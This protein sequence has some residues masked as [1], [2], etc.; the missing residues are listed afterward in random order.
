[1]MKLARY[2]IRLTARPEYGD[3]L[4][5]TLYHTMLATRLPHSDR[6]SPYYSDYGAGAE[7]RYYHR[8]WPCCSGTLVQGVADYV[9]N[10]YF[11][12]DEALYVNL[13]TPSDVSWKTTGW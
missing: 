10:I 7:K 3:G 5:R 1:D 11:H 8:K 13:M 9:L 6:G 4:G 2:L 12:D